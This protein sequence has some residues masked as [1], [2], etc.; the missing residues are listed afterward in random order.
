[1]R[2][3]TMPCCATRSNDCSVPTKAGS[4]FITAW[5]GSRSGTI[6]AAPLDYAAWLVGASARLVGRMLVTPMG[7]SCLRVSDC[8]RRCSGPSGDPNPFAASTTRQTSCEH[9]F[10][11]PVPETLR[12]GGRDAADDTFGHCTEKPGHAALPHQAGDLAH[13]LHSPTNRQAQTTRCMFGPPV[14][15]IVTLHRIAKPRGPRFERRSNGRGSV[16][17]TNRCGSW[18]RTKKIRNEQ[19][20]HFPLERGTILVDAVRGIGIVDSNGSLTP[21][22][23]FM[24]EP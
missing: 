21:E 11:V 9:L 18:F 4:N 3:P 22:A 15:P 19:L 23:Q 16:P 10:I 5:V 20:S 12:F 1:M 2:E 14:L 17:G 6:R 24:N 7:R 13:Q 8:L